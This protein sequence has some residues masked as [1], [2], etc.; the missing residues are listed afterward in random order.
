VTGDQVVRV[1]VFAPPL[2]LPTIG[3]GRFDLRDE[4][5]HPMLVSFLRHAG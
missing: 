5:G 2:D 1:G 4:R 3:G